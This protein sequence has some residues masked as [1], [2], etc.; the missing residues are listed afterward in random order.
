M[1]Q[2]SSGGVEAPDSYIGSFLGIRLW[3]NFNNPSTFEKVII[4]HLV[5]SFF[6]TQCNIRGKWTSNAT[7]THSA[8]KISW[9]GFGTWHLFSKQS[10]QEIF[11][12]HF[13]H[14]SC[15]VVW[16]FEAHKAKTF[17]FVRSLVADDLCFLERR[18]L[19]ECSS[20]IV[21]CHLIA[22]ISTEQSK[23]IYNQ[24]S[25]KNDKWYAG[26]TTSIKV[27]DHLQTM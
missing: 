10:S 27:N 20:Q 6:E 12:I 15:E 26:D 24:K 19:V 4:K 7:G 9:A 14:C 8:T 22:K 25:F 5:Y 3:T 11:T 17:R 13:A 18:I 23:I 21:V 1:W 16:I 2:H